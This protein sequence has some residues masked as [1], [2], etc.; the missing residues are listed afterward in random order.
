[1]SLSELA[2]YLLLTNLCSLAELD[3]AYY[4]TKNIIPPL[5]RI[6]NLVGANVAKW[7][8]EMPKFQRIRLVESIQHQVDGPKDF[9]SKKTDRKSVV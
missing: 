6:F 5:E 2:Q 4:I 9:T 7:Y 1:M 8:D 3:S